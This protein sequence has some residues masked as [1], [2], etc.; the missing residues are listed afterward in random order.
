MVSLVSLVTDGLS[1]SFQF[2]FEKAVISL[3]AV[4]PMQGN[5]QGGVE[6]T[7][8]LD[9]FPPADEPSITFGV[10]S[11]AYN[12]ISVLPSTGGTSLSF[13]FFTPTTSEGS[14]SVQIV[15]RSCF[16]GCDVVE[17]NFEQLAAE[18][19]ELVEPVPNSQP[20]G[21]L[22][23]KMKVRLS[24]IPDGITESDIT[25]TVSSSFAVQVYQ[26]EPTK[27]KEKKKGEYTELTFDDLPSL[28][29]GLYTVFIVVA[30]LEPVSF[31]YQVFAAGQQRTI[32]MDKN[33]VPK[34]A[35]ACGRSLELRSSVTIRV[36]NFPQ[37]NIASN[38]EVFVVN[39]FTSNQLAADLT[40]LKHIQTCPPPE[41][42]CNIT[43]LSI[44]LP[45]FSAVGTQDI[46]IYLSDAVEGQV[47]SSIEVVEGCNW[48]D[49]CGKKKVPDFE[50]ILRAATTECKKKYCV[51]PKKIMEPSLFPI[52]PTR[53]ST[54]GGDE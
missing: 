53:G 51:K 50:E 1:I 30:L 33:E 4:Y 23:R 54:A 27:M 25:A 28:D 43:E 46:I 5:S 41:V 29:I 49:F 48:H 16:S 35:V 15:P 14:F 8:L 39:R 45:A 10:T 19:L 42:G 11:I 38:L 2:V 40:A 34:N 3:I 24:G 21:S 36:S 26:A 20:E 37:D 9:S 13:S 52:G 22:R 12:D 32:G 6:V 17:F 31:E 7:V 18:R 44:R 47:L